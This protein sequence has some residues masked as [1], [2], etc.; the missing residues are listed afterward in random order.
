MTCTILPCRR[1]TA[2]YAQLPLLHEPAE[3]LLARLLPLLYFLVTLLV[4]RIRVGTEEVG[5]KWWEKG[6]LLGF[7]ALESFNS[8]VYPG[9]LAPRLP[10]L[11]LMATSTYCAVGVIYGSYLAARLWRGS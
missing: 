4:V 3:W 7:V 9:L 10:F 2:H 11:P 6:Y 1:S 5:F 8:F